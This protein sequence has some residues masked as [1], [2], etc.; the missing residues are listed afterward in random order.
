MN[1]DAKTKQAV[2]GVIWD[3]DGTL[4]DTEPMYLEAEGAIV[5]RLCGG[6]IS[7]ITHR[8][9]GTTAMDSASIVISHFKLNLTPDKYLAERFDRLCAL[10]QSVQ[11][12]PGVESLVKRFAEL[13]IVQGIATSSPR[14]LLELK[15]APHD[16]L[17]SHFSVIV[18]ADDVSKGKPGKWTRPSVL[19]SKTLQLAYALRRAQE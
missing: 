9:L 1:E 11:I 5:S 8:L 10:L 3:M 15:K 2:H 6:D 16:S 18:C 4:L 17:F 12:M 19:C 13:G 14:N 7:E